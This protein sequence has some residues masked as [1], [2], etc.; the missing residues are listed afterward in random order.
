MPLALRIALTRCLRSPLFWFWLMECALLAAMAETLPAGGRLVW[1]VCCFFTGQLTTGL[2]VD[3]FA[4]FRPR[5]VPDYRQVYLTAMGATGATLFGLLTVWLAFWS[6]A[7]LWPLA[8]WAALAFA[9]GGFMF[10]LFTFF[11]SVM[12]GLGGAALLFFAFVRTSGPLN[13][14]QVWEGLRYA[15]MGWVNVLLLLA[16]GF[17]LARLVQ[18]LWNLDEDQPA[19]DVILRRAWLMPRWRG[20][21][22]AGRPI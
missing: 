15:E 7:P 21:G 9:V 10:S 2:F 22:S 3:R 5:L 6:P 8:G 17:L 13:P 20:G 16:A 11:F 1:P 4:S 19:F 18:R 12:A 14:D